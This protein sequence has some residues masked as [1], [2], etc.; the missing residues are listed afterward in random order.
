MAY[1]PATNTVVSADAKGLIDYWTADA[2]ARFPSPPRR[3][4]TSRAGSAPSIGFVS[5]DSKF[6]ADLFDVAKAKAYPQSIALAPQGD[7]FAVT[8]TDR[9]VRLFDFSSGRLVSSYSDA[10]EDYEA[11]HKA[12]TLG[13]DPL[14]YGR[15]LALEREIT[16]AAIAQTKALVTPQGAGDVVSPV[17][18][19]GHSGSSGASS[20][21]LGAP[22]PPRH[23]PS[24]ALFDE[25]GHFLLFPT[26]LGIKVV[27]TVTGRTCACLGQIENTE[28][29]MGIALFQG[30]PKANAQYAL[31]QAAGKDAAVPIMSEQKEKAEGEGKGSGPA[32][33]LD[34]TIVACAYKRNRFY[35]FSRR[36]PADLTDLKSEGRDVFNEP[37]SKEDLAV[38]AEASAAMQR[39]KLGSEAVVHTT[40]G[41]IFIKLM[42][43][44]APKAVENFC[45]HARSGYYDNHLF[46]RVIKDFMVQTGDPLGDGTGGTSIWGREFEDE[47]SR[48]VRFDRTGVVAMANA[49]PNTNGS[50]W[51]ITTVP[52]P[53]LDGKHTIYG[54]VTRGLDVVKSIEGVPTRPSDD[55][56]YEDIRI[57]NID[58]R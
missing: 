11:G 36:E 12:G 26:M 14:D 1:S 13:L 24:N 40:M 32:S 38:A 55:R 45:G 31:A 57:L 44:L 18:G 29:F 42:P 39:A 41:D 47:I 2:E 50:Q 6:D 43:D 17:G 58:I 25:S 35:L 46:H 19:A 33:R 28:R 56:P 3:P 22:L 20:G 5:F 48:T 21:G 16:A 9:R 51:F 4:A 7:K 52:C 49:G 37:P 30:V 10:I 54:R 23:P 34:P 15:R 8:A 53:W 27:N